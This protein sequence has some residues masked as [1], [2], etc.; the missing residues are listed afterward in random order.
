LHYNYFRTYDP[1]T[2]R[3]LESDPIG[4]H[5]GP[6]SYSYVSSS[7]LDAIDPYG[8]IKWEAAVVGG[9]FG[10][11]VGGTFLRM[12]FVSQCVKGQRA[13]VDINAL[14]GGLGFGWK[15]AAAAITME[16]EDFDVD[17]D[18][19]NLVGTFRMMAAGATVSPVPEMFIGGP[20]VGAS[21]GWMQVGGA[22]STPST[23]LTLGMDFSALAVRGTSWM[24]GAPK[25]ETC[26]CESWE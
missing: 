2:G 17:L 12:K 15:G 6:N 21:R 3:Y 8:N 20:G 26:S 10:V 25:F 14:G 13:E 4:L 7:P 5:G 24:S 19:R 1:T 11:V 23:S 16:F 9:G 18:P 22:F